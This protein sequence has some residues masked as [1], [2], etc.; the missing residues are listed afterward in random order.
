ET[1][2]NFIA[3]EEVTDGQS[4]TIS[5]YLSNIENNKAAFLMTHSQK[6][7]VN[8][9]YNTVGASSATLPIKFLLNYLTSKM[10]SELEFL[11]E[12]KPTI[13]NAKI[14]LETF[15][16]DLPNLERVL[17]TNKP[18]LR[19]FKQYDHIVLQ[20]R[21][22]IIEDAVK[23]ELNKMKNHFE[24][25]ADEIIFSFDEIFADKNNAFHQDFSDLERGPFYLLKLLSD[26]HD[27]SFT[28]EIDTIRKR[29][30]QNKREHRDSVA[31]LDVSRQALMA[32]FLKKTWFGKASL[33][34]NIVET[35]ENYLRVCGKNLM[36]DA[37][38]RVY[39]CFLT[40]LGEFSEQTVDTLCE[41]LNAFKELFDKFK[42]AQ[43]SLV[44][45]NN[46]TKEIANAKDFCEAFEKDDEKN[47]D[48]KQALKRLLK[49]MIANDWHADPQT[50]VENLNDFITQQFQTVVHKSLDYYCSMM[51]N[52]KDQNI[53]DFITERINSLH[54]SAKVM[55]PINHVP[56]GLHIVFP[57]YAYLSVPHNAPYIK[58]VAR[59]LNTSGRVSNIKLSKMCNRL[60]MLN[61]KI[62]VPLYCYTELNEYESVYETS[63]NKLAGMH[64]YESP[65]RNWKELPSPNYDQL[66]TMDYENPRERIKNNRLRDLFD[67][68]LEYKIIRLEER[69]RC[70]FGFFGDEIDLSAR[71]S[72]IENGIEEKIFNAA[73]A[74]AAINE[75]NEFLN[76]GEREKNYRPL[77]DTEYLHESDTPDKNY[78]KGV[79]IFM[80]TLYERVARE[81]KIREYV[82]ALRD[83][84]KK[85]DL[86]EV[87]YSHFAQ[88]LYMGV[89]KKNRKSYRYELNGE[90]KILH[91]MQ[92]ITEQYVDY[93]VFSAYLN[94]DDEVA[95]LLQKNAQEEE[96]RLTDAQFSEIL[97][98]IDTHIASFK[99]KLEQLEKSLS[100]ERDGILKRIFYR[101]MLEVFLQE[102]KVLT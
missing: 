32:K 30:I 95:D 12:K 68:A 17:T 48:Y 83:E 50:L 23:N 2:I 1:I 78:S 18:K 25:A 56:N 90:S 101:T 88:M 84:L 65:E 79:F 86:N 64:L 5:S 3:S 15:K 38:D 14:A 33:A 100:D 97:K 59:Q 26:L 74:R 93:D 8:Y 61:L 57:P 44:L 42:N 76:G 89:I 69:T 35:N 28:R 41:I 10:F 22:E 9:I 31:A 20:Q 7:P 36:Y 46:F 81:V 72:H 27:E 92:N 60:Y 16:I 66:W 52:A 53:E 51:S 45:E 63:F 6:Q 55:F 24:N 82:N 4:Y 39:E 96:N 47:L 54:D 73:Q 91:T 80:P 19:N 77:F 102:K 67:V 99:E 94:L 43:N 87:K 21:P 58:N 34:A 29:D 71:F 75:L 49:E 40:K 37:I 85:I 13:E 11:S 62:A 70:Y 98:L